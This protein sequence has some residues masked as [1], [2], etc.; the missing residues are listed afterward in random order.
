MTS[1]IVVVVSISSLNYTDIP[2]VPCLETSCLLMNN[3]AQ[4]LQKYRNKD[5]YLFNGI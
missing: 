1:V 5:R 4:H 3:A 2:S